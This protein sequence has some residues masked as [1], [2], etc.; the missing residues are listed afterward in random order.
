MKKIKAEEIVLS[1]SFEEL[2][3]ECLFATQGACG[4][5]SPGGSVLSGI[6]LPTKWGM[7]EL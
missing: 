4:G 7:I 1:N 6:K 5:M 3:E 2:D